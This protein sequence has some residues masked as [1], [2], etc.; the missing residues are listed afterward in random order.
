MLNSTTAAAPLWPTTKL[1]RSE[2]PLR[3]W[4]PLCDNLNDNPTMH[5]CLT[6][7]FF[8]L[9]FW[10]FDKA[11]LAKKNNK[12][13]QHQWIFSSKKKKKTKS[14]FPL[15]GAISSLKINKGCW[16]LTLKSRINVHAL[17][18]FFS[19][20]LWVKICLIRS[21][22]LWPLTFQPSLLH[23]FPMNDTDGWKNG[24]GKKNSWGHYWPAPFK[25]Q[26]A[27]LLTHIATI[28]EQPGGKKRS[29][30][31]F[32]S[33]FAYKSPGMDFDRVPA[34]FHR[35]LISNPSFH[36]AQPQDVGAG[37]TGWGVWPD[38]TRLDKSARLS[39]LSSHNIHPWIS[40][41]GCW[42]C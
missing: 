33:H 28:S 31:T 16:C 18:K 27:P 22:E 14:R 24:K 13:P 40:S 1:T 42:P 5:H 37:G 20:H 11:E 25:D 23:H 35:R 10:K 34:K 29:V 41:E 15:R 7:L 32:W 21:V 38:T 12:N 2:E 8:F 36:Q 39:D 4:V 6:T 30:R 26:R 9:R 3:L 19:L 17:K